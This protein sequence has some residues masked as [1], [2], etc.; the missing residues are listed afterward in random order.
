MKQNETSLFWIECCLLIGHAY[1]ESILSFLPQKI[2][3]RKAESEQCHKIVRIAWRKILEY[4]KCCVC[5]ANARF[6]ILEAANYMVYI[7]MR[8]AM[9]AVHF[10]LFNFLKTYHHCHYLFFF[11]LLPLT[12]LCFHQIILRENRFS[13]EANTN[14]CDR[15]AMT[16]FI[17]D[18]FSSEG[19][20][21]EKQVLPDCIIEQWKQFTAVVV[22]CMFV[23]LHKKHIISEGTA[24]TSDTNNNY[25]M[26]VGIKHGFREIVMRSPGRFEIALK[27]SSK[28]L[29]M[30]HMPSLQ[31][32]QRCLPFVPALLNAT[33][34]EHV[35]IC[36]I[37]LVLSMPGSNEQ[38]WHADGGHVDLQ[39]HQSC[40]CLNVF[41]P[42][43]GLTQEM[44]PTELRPGTHYHT[45]N[46]V[47]MMLAAKARKTLQLPV[48]PL[49]QQGDVLVFDYRILHRGLANASQQNRPILVLTVAQ[50]WFKDVLNFPSRS[51]QDPTENDS[52]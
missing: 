13:N 23:E 43:I 6:M 12:I 11:N 7:I 4:G 15:K 24:T 27:E 25:P 26:K 2:Y 16:T 48:S 38:S 39:K 9:S 21:W 5:A 50:T 44:G 42:L 51:L 1:R 45:R 33:S 29:Q 3:G 34:W 37:S 47:P 40:H 30:N 28:L 22:E 18:R 17:Q 49:L 36:H 8:L 32:L 46:L 35:Q 31:M 20:W 41:I 14:D 52:K 10:N 19:Y